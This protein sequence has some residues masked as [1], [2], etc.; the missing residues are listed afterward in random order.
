MSNKSML[1]S[2]KAGTFVA[3]IIPRKIGIKFASSVGYSFGLLPTNL[4]K[5][6]EKI[7][8]VI[9]PEL[10]SKEI[11]IRAAQ[12]ISSYSSYW[13]DVFWLSSKRKKS[14]LDDILSIEGQLNYDSTIELAKE[15]GTGII[16][17]LPHLGSWEIAGSWIAQN[18]FPPVVVAER[19]KLPELFEIFTRTRTQA[20][21]TVVAHDDKPTAKLIKA[22][23]E[24]KVICLVA[25][26]DISRRGIEVQFFSKTKTLP[27]GPA[28]LALKTGAPILPLCTYLSHDG[29]I[30]L[31]VEKVISVEDENGKKSIAQITEEIGQSLEKMISRDPSQW[32]VLSY[33]WSD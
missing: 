7:Q 10:S 13:W 18:G 4:R 24:E 32:H 21:M 15:L 25:D 19:L 16:A 28:S 9:S 29:S 12:V 6:I 11:K 1:Y 8:L 2:L 20:G 27:A 26:R 30:T 14:A 17:V 33:E 5:K 22:L 3:K 23:R 31:S